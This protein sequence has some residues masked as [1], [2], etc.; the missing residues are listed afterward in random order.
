[1]GRY[2]V[3]ICSLGK[4][5]TLK[6][7]P[8]QSVEAQPQYPILVAKIANSILRSPIG[9]FWQTYQVETAS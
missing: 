7:F 5:K 1:M 9:G 3:P 6:R 8:I 4:L 2:D